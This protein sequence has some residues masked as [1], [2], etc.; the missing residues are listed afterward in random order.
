MSKPIITKTESVTIE[1]KWDLSGL[2]SQVMLDAEL[3]SPTFNQMLDTFASS[4]M[5]ER[6]KL[7]LILIAAGHSPETTRL[8]ERTWYDE[9]NYEIN[10]ECWSMSCL[11][12]V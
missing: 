3:K 7:C 8:C 9:E 1:R 11:G 2:D 4:V 6:T 12:E 10:Y 5:R